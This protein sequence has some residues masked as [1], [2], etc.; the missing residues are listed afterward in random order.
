MKLKIVFAAAIAAAGLGAAVSAL[1][2]LETLNWS[3]SD[4]RAAVQETTRYDG[5]WGPAS[6]LLN[7]SNRRAVKALDSGARAQLVTTAAPIVKALIMSPAFM[8]A[9]EAWIA[10]Q[11]DAVNH[12]IKVAGAQGNTE[13]S[14]AQ[15]Q[16]VQRKLGAQIYEAYRSF[17]VNMI[18]DSLAQELPAWQEGL[19]DSSG[20][21]RARYQKLI[22]KA[23]QI[24]PLA[25]TDPAA[26]Q[27]GY[28]I[29]K[30]IE[31]GGPD[32]EADLI[33]VGDQSKKHQQQRNYDQYNL[34]SVLKK[35]LNDFVRVAN[36]IDYAAATATVGNRERFTDAKYEKTS[37]EWKLLYRFGKVP[38]QA[39]AAFAQRWAREL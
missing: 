17:P 39:A 21:D 32:N 18:K 16:D 12:N 36:S 9:H 26:F 29:L 22:A 15:M 5:A 23:K 38:S 27:K 33:S 7:S 8:Q 30:S 11:L 6:K 19:K 31:S 3:E 13:D 1:P 20:A 25:A 37:S 34:R 14:D 2:G 4:I 24:Q 10:T 28:G 35:R